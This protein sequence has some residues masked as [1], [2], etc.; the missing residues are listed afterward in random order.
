VVFGQWIF[1]QR[2]WKSFL[3]WILH[4]HFRHLCYVLCF[5]ISLLQSTKSPLQSFKSPTEFTNSIDQSSQYVR[6]PF[7]SLPPTFLPPGRSRWVR[8]SGNEHHV[9]LIGWC[10][11]TVSHIKCKI[12]QSCLTSLMFSSSATKHS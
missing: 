1:W 11:N 6:N 5:D 7:G 10:R 2:L 8:M 9:I 4:F 12:S 3:C